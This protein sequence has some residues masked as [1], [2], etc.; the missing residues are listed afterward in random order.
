MSFQREKLEFGN[1]SFVGNA[2]NDPTFYDLSVR[3]QAKIVGWAIS[4]PVAE[5]LTDPQNPNPGRG[6][7]VMLNRY[8]ELA[9]WSGQINRIAKEFNTDLH[10][11]LTQSVRRLQSEPVGKYEPESVSESYIS[12]IPPTKTLVGYT[13]PRLMTKQLG[14]KEVSPA[15]KQDRLVRGLDILERSM[16]AAQSPEELL[17]FS[18]EAMAQADVDPRIVLSTILNTG[19]YKEQNADSMVTALKAALQADA[20]QLWQLYGSL[21]EPDKLASNI[22]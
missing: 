2:L 8:G 19:W 15:E 14:G 6:P 3:E 11:Q 1:G 21:S 13:L 4:C 9:F 5:E 22:L 12:E 18:A 20:P 16:I 7:D 17:A 10:V